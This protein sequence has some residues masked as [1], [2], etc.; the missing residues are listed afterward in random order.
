MWRWSDLCRT[1][2]NNRV[3]TEINSLI[4][5]PGD[6]TLL[7]RMFDTCG[8]ISLCCMSVC[9]CHTEVLACGLC[10]CTQLMFLI[11]DGFEFS[12]VSSQFYEIY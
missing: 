2:L 8:F 7:D 10:I 11:G 3:I 9:L 5:Q 6:V 4:E 12:L 1:I